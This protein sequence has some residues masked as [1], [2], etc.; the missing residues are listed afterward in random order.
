[1]LTFK[2]AASDTTSKFTLHTTVHLRTSRCRYHSPSCAGPPLLTPCS[3]CEPCPDPAAQTCRSGGGGGVVAAAWWRLQLGGA[4]SRSAES[5]SCRRRQ[6]ASGFSVETTRNEGLQGQSFL[7]QRVPAEFARRPR[8]HECV[9]QQIFLIW[10]PYARAP[11]G[12]LGARVQKLCRRAVR[13]GVVR[14]SLRL[15]LVGQDLFLRLLLLAGRLIGG[16]LC[17]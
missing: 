2:V 13:A 5:K 9:I 1:M 16:F 3:H 15:L 11:V 8:K 4:A 6:K 7:K 12:G 10:W 14:R 17:L